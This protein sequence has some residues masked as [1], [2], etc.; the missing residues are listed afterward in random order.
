MTTGSG[1]AAPSSTFRSR[2]IRGAVGAI[3]LVLASGAGVVAALPAA[4]GASTAHGSSGHASSGHALTA[5]VGTRY[6]FQKLGDP[7][8]PTFNQLLGINDEGVIAGY[9]GSG[10]PAN[11]HPNKG[12][13][14]A[15]YQHQQF[16][17]E[18]FPGSV[19]TQ[20]I[21]INDSG[22]TVGFWAD[23]AGNNFGFVDRK[24]HFTN[25]SYP[26]AGGSPAVTQLLGINNQGVAVGFYNDAAGTPH[27]FEYNLHTGAYARIMVPGA[28]SSMAT[29]I[30]NKGDISG[31]ATN[32][33]KV[34]SAYLRHAGAF[35][36][37]TYPGASQTQAFGLNDLDQVAGQF[38]DAAGKMHGFIY[39]AGAFQALDDPA[40]IGTTLIN[41]INDAGDLVGF[42]TDGARNTD[43]FVAFPQ[44][45][46]APGA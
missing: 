7:A 9:F 28:V 40:G 42:Y 37:L 2:R 32:A 22:T 18:N 31:I 16:V 1:S 6:Q 44:H 27:G 34:T 12:F 8:D 25:V 45:F 20:V 43:G 17:N 15:P 33:S 14:I 30:N 21:G 29:G 10:N 35:R 39:Q 5:G 38:V 13:T 11:V 41:G 24:G 4:A 46:A 3:A 26:G 23:A 19:Q 36:T